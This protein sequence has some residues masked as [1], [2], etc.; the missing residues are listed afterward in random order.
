MKRSI[1][2]RN[3]RAAEKV[4]LKKEA[5]KLIDVTPIV[6]KDV[7]TGKEKISFESFEHAVANGFNFQN[8]KK[9]IKNGTKYKGHLWS[10]V[11]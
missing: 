8:L 3:M 6:A 7:E 11:E 10:I 5:V 4:A 1:L 9:A 2:L